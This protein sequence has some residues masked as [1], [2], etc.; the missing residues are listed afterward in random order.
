MLT[1]RFLKSVAFS[2]TIIASTHQYSKH[3]EYLKIN[4]LRSIKL[5]VAGSM[6]LGTE[7]SAITK[8]FAKHSDRSTQ[9][10][11]LSPMIF[12]QLYLKYAS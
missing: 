2:K 7:S 10:D 11:L 8:K 6:D 12:H 5:Y 9:T 4:I 3:F 1:I